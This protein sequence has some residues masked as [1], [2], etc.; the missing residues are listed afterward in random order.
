MKTWPQIGTLFTFVK[1]KFA[2]GSRPTSPYFPLSLAIDYDQP[3]IG[4]MSSSSKHPRCWVT[5]LRRVSFSFFTQIYMSAS[6]LYRNGPFL[7]PAT[8]ALR[9]PRGLWISHHQPWVHIPSIG[10]YIEV[11]GCLLSLAMDGTHFFSLLDSSDPSIAFK[12]D[13]LENSLSR[14]SQIDQSACSL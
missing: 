2:G 7:D 1:L 14:S 5:Q 13:L 6:G 12:L 3:A 8:V 11:H 4:L 10:N 9:M